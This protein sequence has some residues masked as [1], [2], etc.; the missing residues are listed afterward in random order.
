MDQL[1][2]G[3]NCSSSS[4]S[5]S[6]KVYLASVVHLLVHFSEVLWWCGCVLLWM[7]WRRL[8]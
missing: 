8:P 3:Q 6:S 4:S 1:L 5:S 7:F 2:Q